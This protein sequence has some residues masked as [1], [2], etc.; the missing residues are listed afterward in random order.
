[1]KNYEAGVLY[2]PKFVLNESYFEI[3]EFP[4]PYDVPLKKYEADDKPFIN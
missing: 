2:L 1:M 4:L 3:D